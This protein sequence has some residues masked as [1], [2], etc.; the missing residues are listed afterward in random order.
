MRGRG[1]KEES[2]RR[3]RGREDEKG[4]VGGGGDTKRKGRKWGGRGKGEREGG[5]K[6]EEGKERERDGG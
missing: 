6:N 2:G 5:R 4:K 1:G 3:E